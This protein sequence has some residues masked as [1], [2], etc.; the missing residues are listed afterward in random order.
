MFASAY[1]RRTFLNLDSFARCATIFNH[2]KSEAEVYSELSGLCR[3]DGYVHAIAYICFRDNVIRYADEIRPEDVLPMFSGERL[4]RTEISTLIGLMVQGDIDWRVPAPPIFQEY[5]ERTESLLKELHQ[6]FLPPETILSELGDAAHS[7]PDF[8]GRGSVLREAIFYG[9]ESAYNFQ[10]RDFSPDKYAADAGWLRSHK[11]FTISEARDVV[12]AI[13]R[14][15]EQKLMATLPQMRE[16]PSELWTFLPG[17]TFGVGE[18][19][20]RCE[21][22]SSTILAVLDAFALPAYEKNASFRAIDDFNAVNARPL[23]RAGDDF[24]SF[25]SYSLAEALYESP[26]YWMLDDE[27]Y[28]PT[29][30]TNRGT[31]TEDF[32]RKRLDQVFGERRVQ[33]NVNIFESK[34][35]RVAEID[36]LVLFGDRAVV[37]QAKSKRLTLESRKG[38]DGRIRDDF[39][40]SVQDSYDQGLLC[41]QKLSDPNATFVRPDGKTVHIP[42]ALKEIYILCV[43]SDHY[44]ALHFQS[45]QFLKWRQTDLI[46]PPL[47]LDVFALDAIAEMLSSPLRFLSYINRRVGYTGRLIANHEMVILSYHLKRNLWIESDVDIF[48]LEDDISADLDIAMAA[49]REGVSGRRVPDGVLTRTSSS[50]L[51]WIIADIEARPEPGVIDLGFL[52]LSLNEKMILD[53]SRGIQRIIHLA[54]RDSRVHDITV[55]ISSEATGLTVHCNSEQESSAAARLQNHCR[56]RKYSEKAR[57]WFGI[58]L[59]PRDSSLRF[60][61]K[62]DYEW[63]PDQ[64]L[65]QLTRGAPRPSSLAQALDLLG[66]RRKIGRNDLCPCG[67]GKKYKKCHGNCS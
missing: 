51:G 56:R 39:K 43:V 64:E 67:S 33:T 42:L 20:R 7:G 27:T 15:Q 59:H 26:F 16:L 31:F 44:P 23:L 1:P 55:G 2:M 61:L 49:R 53:V 58:C 40:K 52:L 32:C 28:A 38:N 25:Q 54:R 17:F 29:A 18:I 47:V 4:L 11:G 37:V 12:Y 6:A 57:T 41:A 65:D 13:A 9:G 60:G 48:M 36:V 14:E 22:P 19:A 5:L 63:I 3:S 10:Y 34:G 46:N 66:R 45:R 62:L 24:V 35:K 30:L 21:L 8:F 50:A